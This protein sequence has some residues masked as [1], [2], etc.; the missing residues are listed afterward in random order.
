MPTSAKTV[1]VD[2]V[3]SPTLPNIPSNISQ[4]ELLNKIVAERVE[5]SK[6][7]AQTVISEKRNEHVLE[8]SEQAKLDEVLSLCAEYDKQMQWE[9][10]NKPTPN[11][12]EYLQKNGKSSVPKTIKKTWILLDFSKS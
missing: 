4:E 11:R 3:V 10:N 2:R 5:V 1:N 7:Q 12:L 6:S 9:K 8:K